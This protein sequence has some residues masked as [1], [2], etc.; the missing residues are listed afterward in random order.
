MG[1]AGVERFFLWKLI[2]ENT[3]AIQGSILI[4]IDVEISFTQTR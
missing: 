3:R 4:K 1:S 2:E